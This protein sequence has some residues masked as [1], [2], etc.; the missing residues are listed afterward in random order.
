VKVVRQGSPHPTL[1]KDLLL[2]S[3]WNERGE[4]FLSIT[5]V[6]FFHIGT[7]TPALTGRAR[8]SRGG[9]LAMRKHCRT[10]VHHHHLHHQYATVGVWIH[11]MRLHDDLFS[12]LPVLQVRLCTRSR[13]GS[14][15][16]GSTLREEQCNT[17]DHQRGAGQGATTTSDLGRTSVN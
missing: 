2:T 10:K 15:P 9:G 5:F 13:S 14:V 8:G 11:C 4:P 17:A 6:S 16:G 3:P 7:L 12:L 1:L